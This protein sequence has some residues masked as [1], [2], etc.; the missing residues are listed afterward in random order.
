MQSKLDQ[1]SIIN[2]ERCDKIILKLEIDAINLK[3]DL[4]RQG[5][6]WQ[7]RLREERVSLEFER[8]NDVRRVQDKYECLLK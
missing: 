5:L 7:E 3:D 2:H 8:M 6:E 4:K 1:V